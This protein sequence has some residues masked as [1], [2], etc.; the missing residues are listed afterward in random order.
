MTSRSPSRDGLRLYGRHYRKILDDGVARRPVL[1]LA[2]LTR[3]G[4]DFHEIALALSQT[5]NCPR[6]VY[7]LD[8]RGRGLSQWDPDPK[9]YSVVVEMLDALD[10]MTL[11]GIHGASSSARRVAGSSP[12]RW[13]PRN[14]QR[15]GLSC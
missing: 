1:C 2:G 3:N 14:P 6:D 12:W 10:F 5:P 4:R 7:T 11:T 13:R 15:S 9:N 8:S